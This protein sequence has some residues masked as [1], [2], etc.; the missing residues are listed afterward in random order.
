MTI[1]KTGEPCGKAL[2]SLGFISIQ[3][4]ALGMVKTY[5]HKTDKSD[6]SYTNLHSVL[7]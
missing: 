5:C 6:Y 2:S 4:N 3:F 1:F 7:V